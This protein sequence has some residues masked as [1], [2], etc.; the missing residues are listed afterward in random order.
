VLVV[1]AIASGVLVAFLVGLIISFYLATVSMEG[2][3]L[4]EQV[5][6]AVVLDI[7]GD[8]PVKCGEAYQRFERVLGE[9]SGAWQITFGRRISSTYWEF[10]PAE[11]EGNW[12]Q[13][14]SARISLD[15]T[16]GDVPGILTPLIEYAGRPA[17][18]RYIAYFDEEGGPPALQ[19][20]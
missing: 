17:P 9:N 11:C 20:E 14:D 5:S 12:I 13:V 4:A 1:T 10:T 18:F 19:R 3:R 7:L 2:Q 15:L 8:K 6:S 16:R